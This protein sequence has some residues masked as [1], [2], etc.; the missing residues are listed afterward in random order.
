MNQ[1]RP[2]ALGPLVAGFA[3]LVLL[4]TLFTDW[5][6]PGLTAWTAFE[7][8]DLVLAAL[9]LTAI[10]VCA[11][12]LG[13]GLV[14]TRLPPGLLLGIAAAAL[15][16][17]VSQLINHPPRAVDRSAEP[18]IW[19][20]RGAGLVLLAGAA[21]GSSYVSVVRVDEAQGGGSPQETPAEHDA[22]TRPMPPTDPDRPT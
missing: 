6:E 3:A 15:L 14:K 7:A 5:Y 4:G 21:L 22:P 10:A 9:A 12:D 2:I 20:A 16:I 18:G 13:A 19:V 11:Q 1:T 17:V 8:L